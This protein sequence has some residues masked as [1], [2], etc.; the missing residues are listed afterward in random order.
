[1]K[2]FLVRVGISS[3]VIAWILS[4]LVVSLAKVPFPTS[5]SGQCSLLEFVAS[6]VLVSPFFVFLG[7]FFYIWLVWLLTGKFR[8]P[9]PFNDFDVD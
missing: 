3:Y 1:M 7:C 2:A 5:C 4:V 8:L 6:L 9:W